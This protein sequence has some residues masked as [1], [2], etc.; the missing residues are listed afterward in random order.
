MDITNALESLTEALKKR[1]R[2]LDEREAELNEKMARVD[3]DISK[4][5]GNTRP[6]DV[7]HLN[8]G[9]Q[10][11]DVL[12]RTLCSIEGS[13]LAAKFSGRWDDSLEKDENG[14]FFMDHDFDDFKIM[15]NFLRDKAIETPKFPVSAPVG[16]CKFFRLLEYYGMTDGVYP[17]RLEPRYVTDDDS[18]EISK[19]LQINAKEWCT[20]EVIQHGHTRQIVSFEVR[21]GKVQRLQIGLQIDDRTDNRFDYS[22]S[23]GVGDIE[24]T[25][26]LDTVRSCVLNA[27]TRNDIEG[28]EVKE[29]SIIKIELCGKWYI[30]GKL[31]ASADENDGQLNIIKS[32]RQH[33]I[34][35][36][37]MTPAISIKGEANIVNVDY[38]I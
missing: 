10:R 29:G 15:I 19:G 34:S 7:L 31:V 37:P 16:T 9:G 30:D 18:F 25:Y 11:I 22:Q 1:E 33:T 24:S 20:F 2:E 4:A 36:Y 8:I 27:G 17:I 5:Y 28:L 23:T 3:V 21:L 38:K 6:T 12:R 14:H 13:M 35:R 26:A 32:P